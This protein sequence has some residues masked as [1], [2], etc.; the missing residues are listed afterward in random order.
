[1]NSAGSEFRLTE[2]GIPIRNVWHMLV[3]AWQ[4]PDVSKRLTL[5]EVESAPS[6]DALFALLL[7][8]ALQQRMRLG[9]GQ[10]YGD[11]TRTVRG[12]RGRINF[13]ESI[14]RQSFE[15]GEAVCDFQE[16]SVNEPRNQVIRSTLQRLVQRGAFGP[17]EARAETLRQHLRWLVRNLH[18]VDRIELNPGM[19]R[20]L[21]TSQNEPDYRFLLALC[22]L[23][24]LHGMPA[25]ASGTR[26]APGL[27]REALVLHRIYE[28]FVAAF[29]RVHL[30]GWDV[31]AQKR[32]DW[33]AEQTNE[34]LPAMIPD[35]I[36]THR[37]TGQVVLL[38]TKFTAA[39]LVENR[40]GKAVYDST[41][42]YQMYAYLR[43]QEQM[44]EAQ[45]QAAGILLYPAVN[46]RGSERV[47]V[48]GH[49]IHIEW[50]D[51]AAP[52]QEVEKQL[53]DIVSGN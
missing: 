34:H 30:K 16:Y 29:F 51:L 4:E 9:L 31:Q 40:W 35:V 2:H 22:E 25:D 33:H 37:E 10:A 36:L 52:W 27:E 14:K 28:R 53:M 8:H 48:Q 7:S 44:S 39:S 24:I 45:K 41:H 5:D 32:L 42:L 3:Y 6:L 17:D 12:I 13:A 46:S 47:Q 50:L 43:S 20:R 1:V 38:D 18:G 49:A 26:S 23:V 11:Q 19:V 15:N 21:Q